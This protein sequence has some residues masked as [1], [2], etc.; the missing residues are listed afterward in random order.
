M[1]SINYSERFGGIQRLYGKTRADIIPGLH[2]CVIGI[3]GVGS[4]AVEALARS[5][6]GK[7]TLLD[8][9]DISLSNINRQIHTLDTT[10]NQAKVLAM[11]ERVLQINPDCHCHAIDDLLT[12]NNLS[13]YFNKDLLK[14]NQIKYDYVIDAIDNA[15]HKSALIYYCKRN[16]IP[17]ITTGGAGG[18]SNPTAIEICDLSKTYNDPLA[19][20]VRSQLRQKYNFTRN[21]Q[22]RFGVECVFSTEQ[23]LY[24]Q[25][26]GSIGQ[27]KPK[28][29]GVSLDCNYG[30]GSS[31][32]VTSVFGFAAA[33]RVIDK[34]LA[35]RERSEAGKSKQ[36]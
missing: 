36:L 23:Q 7:I 20:S 13:K 21:P 12:E 32:C 14:N 25:A 30:Y 16:K 35:R 10:I 19:A 31:C 4:W 29:K 27:E 34:S 26:D 5:G 3:G 17:I 15:K 9:D 18:L 8:N 24:P 28:T 2:I 22:S 33:A 11:K 6:V 1:V